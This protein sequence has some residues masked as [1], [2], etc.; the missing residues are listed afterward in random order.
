MS[1][2]QNFFGHLRMYYHM[3]NKTADVMPFPNFV[4]LIERAMRYDQF[5]NLDKHLAPQVRPRI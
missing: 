2:L 1:R 3:V 4:R 5:I